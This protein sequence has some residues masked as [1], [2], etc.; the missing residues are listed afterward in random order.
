MAR[1]RTKAAGQ[2]PMKKRKPEPAPVQESDSDSDDFMADEFDDEQ[3]READER[4]APDSRD[5]RGLAPM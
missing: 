3:L 5:A 4:Y 1:K 2:P